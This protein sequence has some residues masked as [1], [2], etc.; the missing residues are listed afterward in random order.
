MINIIISKVGCFLPS[1]VSTLVECYLPDT[2]SFLT[3]TV[4]SDTTLTTV[5]VSA[6]PTLPETI[7]L[8]IE[9]VLSNPLEAVALIVGMYLVI[10]TTIRYS[11]RLLREYKKELKNV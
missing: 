4:L 8:L 7:G 6:K 2:L 5:S 1:T 3:Q 11:G 9:L 10:S